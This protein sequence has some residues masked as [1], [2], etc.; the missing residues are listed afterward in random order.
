MWEICCKLLAEL[1]YRNGAKIHSFVLM[2]NHYHLLIS[3][4]EEN[5]Y[6]C[7]RY[8]Q[9]EISRW[10]KK[11]TL[12]QVFGFGGRYKYSIIKYPEHYLS[13]Y[14]YVYQNPLRAGIVDRV[15]NYKWSTVQA[16]LGL[17][18][19][20]FPLAKHDYSYLIPASISEEL[21][22]LN[23]T[24][25]QSELEKLRRGLRKSIFQPPKRLHPNVEREGV[26]R[27]VI[28]TF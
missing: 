20:Q 10:L 17:S 25:S 8:F 13:V 1:E 28:G 11:S 21:R 16:L 23:L 6:E 7:I 9:T 18:S 22:W 15:E 26:C 5:L 2:S 3:T 4:P 24:Q 12:K 14:R 27:K 19:L